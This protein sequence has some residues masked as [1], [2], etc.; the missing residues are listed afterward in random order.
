[1]ANLILK[2]HLNMSRNRHRRSVLYTPGA[3]VR[4]LEKA[5]LLNADGF[6]LD[7]EDAVAP[8]AKEDARENVARAIESGGYGGK[9][10]LVRIN[11]LDTKWGKGDLEIVARSAADGIVIPKVE[12]AENVREVRAIMI[13]VGAPESMRIW[14]MIETPRGVLRAEEIAGSDAQLGGLIMGT[15]DLAKELGCAHTRMR[16]PMLASLGRCVLVARAYGLSILDGVH[17][18][19]DD[20]KGF[21]L[22]CEQGREFGFNGKTLIHPKTIDK[23]N[24]IF[25]PNQDEL[26]WAKKI[27]AAYRQGVAEG[28]GVVVVDG[29][30]IENLHVAAAQELLEIS[31]ALSDSTGEA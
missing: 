14:C 26:N 16:L 25:S 17:L 30:L 9:E 24:E 20:A 18:D 10:V 13:E 4:A 21:Q 29:H 1:M 27:I 11:S 6:I 7:L 12:S 15:S 28:K 22:S 31:K 2:K 19:L 23:A 3:N 5:K 8:D